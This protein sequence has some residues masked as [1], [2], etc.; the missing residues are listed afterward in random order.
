MADDYRFH[1]VRFERFAADEDPK[2]ILDELAARCRQLGV[3]WIAADGGGHGHVY[4][5]LLYDR[6]QVLG[7]CAILYSAS[8][9]EPQRDGVLT[10]WTVD[11]SATI[12]VLISRIK[13]RQV[14]F[15]PVQESGS[16]LDEF[17]C[18][19][20]EYD[21]I[22][23]KIKYT[24][25]ESQMDDALHATNYALLVATRAYQAARQHG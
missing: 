15:P 12:G 4:N 6:I 16:F 25:P 10:K 8:D 20:A 17:A 21:D 13:N 18:E 22:N 5:R 3:R 2:R 23:R 7:H 14:A 9:H 24:H 1:V 11:R 19:I